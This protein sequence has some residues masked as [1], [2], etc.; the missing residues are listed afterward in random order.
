[1][2]DKGIDDRKLRVSVLARTSH[3]AGNPEQVDLTGG[4][5]D[6]YETQPRDLWKFPFKYWHTTTFPVYPG[7]GS[8]ACDGANKI[9]RTQA[10]KYARRR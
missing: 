6:I 1:M 5:V 2:E 3:T 9:S 4:N 10:R 7:M 8:I